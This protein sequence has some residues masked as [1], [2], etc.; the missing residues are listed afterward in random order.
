MQTWD[1]LLRCR[2]W[3]W[4]IG[5]LWLWRSKGGICRLRWGAVREWWWSMIALWHFRFKQ[6]ERTKRVCTD[7]WMNNY[8]GV[9]VVVI[10]TLCYTHKPY[11]VL[12]RRDRQ[13]G[14]CTRE[15]T[16]MLQG[17]RGQRI[18]LQT[19]TLTRSLFRWSLHAVN[20]VACRRNRR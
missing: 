19:C 3:W 10:E 8:R 20:Q 2:S 6:V 7:I 16:W 5:V 17:R 4:W 12:L 13:R 9:V 15:I 1:N 18:R 11:M 14:Q